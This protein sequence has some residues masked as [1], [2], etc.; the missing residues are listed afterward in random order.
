MST[1]YLIFYFY[2][3]TS[4]NN[5]WNFNKLNQG[6]LSMIHPSLKNYFNKSNLIIGMELEYVPT[7][8]NYQKDETI[9]YCKLNQTML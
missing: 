1:C 8:V 4:L 6:M 3:L 2:T 7:I 9:L 5:D